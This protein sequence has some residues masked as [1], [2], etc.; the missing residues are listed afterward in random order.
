MNEEEESNG[1]EFTP[2]YLHCT[3]SAPRSE[4]ESSLVNFIQIFLSCAE[5]NPIK[6]ICNAKL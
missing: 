6:T 4:A 2:E 5:F 3:C 1:D